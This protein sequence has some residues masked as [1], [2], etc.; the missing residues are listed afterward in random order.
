MTF[1]LAVGPQLSVRTTVVK[2]ALGLAQE[3][4]PASSFV[5]GHKMDGCSVHQEDL[6]NVER[7]STAQVREHIHITGLG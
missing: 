3:T 6:V 1:E 7:M 2:G 5:C 4:I